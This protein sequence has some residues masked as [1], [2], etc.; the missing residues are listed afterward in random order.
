[1][2][3]RHQY[4]ASS[5]KTRTAQHRKARHKEAQYLSTLKPAESKAKPKKH[6]NPIEKVCFNSQRYPGYSIAPLL[7]E[8]LEKG[9][10]RSSLT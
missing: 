8:A 6:K 5:K 3:K 10:A 4:V 7:Q 9:E 1:M 2:A